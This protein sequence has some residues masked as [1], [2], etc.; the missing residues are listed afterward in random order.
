[1][2]G[3]TG[4]EEAVERP[5]DRHTAQPLGDFEEVTSKVLHTGDPFIPRE[6]GLSVAPVSVDAE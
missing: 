1:M 2:I 5:K 4:L 3:S 6:W